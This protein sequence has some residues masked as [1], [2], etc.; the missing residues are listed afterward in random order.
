MLILA[1]STLRAA[2]TIERQ[3]AIIVIEGNRLP[4]PR[5]CVRPH[6]FRV[7]NSPIAVRHARLA[8]LQFGPVTPD[9]VVTL[10]A[11]GMGSVANRLR[12]MT[13]TEPAGVK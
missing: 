10:I 4:P 3:A 1:G 8:R 5:P 2:T 12:V 7:G 13:P 9:M 11:T 6:K